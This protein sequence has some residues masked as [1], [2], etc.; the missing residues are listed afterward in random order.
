MN[1]TLVAFASKQEFSGVFP[2]LTATVATTSPYSIDNRFDVCVCG[3]GMVEFS[4]NLAYFLAKGGYKCVVQVGICGVYPNRDFQVGEVV[5]V[6]ADALGDMG[7]QTREG[8]FVPWH[9]VYGEKLVYSGESP[10]ALS[11]ALASIPSAVGVTVSCCTGTRYLALR[12]GGMFKADVETME[13]AACFAVC[14]RFGVPAYQFRAISNVATD[15]DT[16]TW[17]V[18][19]AL[20]ALKSQ[21]LDV[22]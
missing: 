19:E 11:L 21:V 10:R 15:R 13:G 20:A 3:V 8:H 22:L 1:D 18:P 2:H 4:A 16:S 5:R 7:V 12:R 9:D 17:K 14:K 6:D